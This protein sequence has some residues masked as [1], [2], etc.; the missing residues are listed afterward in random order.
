MASTD[1]LI[2]YEGLPEKIVNE[3]LLWNDRR[4]KCSAGGDQKLRLKIFNMATAWRLK[5]AATTRS[6]LD[7]IRGSVP[8]TMVGR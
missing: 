8:K 1:P 6:L 4:A 3:D 2:P 7:E 5:D